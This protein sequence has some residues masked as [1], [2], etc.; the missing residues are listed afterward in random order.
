MRAGLAQKGFTLLELLVVLVLLGI[1][2]VL[3]AP[4]VGGSLQAAR[5]KT[6]ARGLLVVLREQRGQAISQGQ[7][8]TLNFT[9]EGEY[10]HLENKQVDLPSGI[11][12]ILQTSGGDGDKPMP[13]E[14]MSG[15]APNSVV[16]YPDG[17]S[18]GGVLQV[19]LEDAV[20]YIRIDWLTGEVVLRDD[21][22]PSG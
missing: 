2:S 6:E 15:I 8:I 1:I 9:A 4:S 16:F 17:S 5:L 20:R 13:A 11:E 14:L 7:P 12:V 19:S 10:Y 21:M 18:S 22:E 3:V